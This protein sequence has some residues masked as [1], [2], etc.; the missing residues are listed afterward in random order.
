[1]E[2]AVFVYISA[3]VGK[4]SFLGEIILGVSIV[5]V[6]ALILMVTDPFTEFTTTIRNWLIAIAVVNL[7]FLAIPSEKTLWMM[8]AAYASQQVITSSMS[9][10]VKILIEQKLDEQLAKP[11]TK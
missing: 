6:V 5:A 11:L 4:L 3:L 8:A 9:D 10:K 7:L 2:F 1:M